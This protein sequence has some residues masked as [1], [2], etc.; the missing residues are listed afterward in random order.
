[1]THTKEVSLHFYTLTSQSNIILLCPSISV[2]CLPMPE[3]ESIR[4]SGGELDGDHFILCSCLVGQQR[5]AQ[6]DVAITLEAD[7]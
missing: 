6:F 4:F 7:F 1:M 3:D 2:W 5:V